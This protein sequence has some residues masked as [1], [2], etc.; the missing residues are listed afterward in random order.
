M[1]QIPAFAVTGAILATIAVWAF[2][3][4]PGLLVWAAF[5]GWACVA[6]A[7]SDE[8]ALRKTLTSMFIGVAIAWAMA[9]LMLNDKTGLPTPILAALIVGI[10]T[11]IVILLSRFDAL[12]LVP[13]VFYGFAASFAYMVQ[14]PNKFTTQALL[15]PTL[16]NPIAIMPL[17]L[18]IGCHHRLYPWPVCWNAD[19]GLKPERLEILR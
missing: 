13:A 18:A 1:P 19:Q 7:G 5:I 8:T 6:Q 17:S 12:S 4:F 10:V 2:L 11:T 9:M 14:T 15:S 3:Q 16:D